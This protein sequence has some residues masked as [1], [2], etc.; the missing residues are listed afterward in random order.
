ML[1]DTHSSQALTAGVPE[2]LR[3]SEGQNVEGLGPPW[4]SS[5]GLSAPCLDMSASREKSLDHDKG[6]RCSTRVLRSSGHS[7]MGEQTPPQLDTWGQTLS[8]AGVW[9]PDTSLS[10]I[11][12]T[13]DH[14][15]QTSGT[16]DLLGSPSDHSGGSCDRRVGDAP[17]QPPALAPRKS[18]FMHVLFMCAHM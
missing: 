13:Q 17:A 3:G 10:W 14:P 6:P 8:R 12:E 2:E 15:G 5:A 11:R 9:G 1:G 7:W 4:A 16:Q 18:L